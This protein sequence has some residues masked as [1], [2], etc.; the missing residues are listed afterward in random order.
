MT[1]IDLES[2]SLED[3]PYPMFKTTRGEK[4]LLKMA[5]ESNKSIYLC[6]RLAYLSLPTSS[7]RNKI[8]ISLNKGSL[9][10]YLYRDKNIPLSY[11]K[12]NTSELRNIWIRKLLEYKGE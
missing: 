7:L 12:H 3:L 9:F 8:E 6:I 1:P 10:T 4:S 5:L 11:D 2:V